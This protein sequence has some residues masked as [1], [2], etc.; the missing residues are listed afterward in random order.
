MIESGQHRFLS[1]FER[2]K[3]EFPNRE[4]PAVE[5]VKAKSENG[6]TFDCIEIIRPYV[7][8]K[9]PI[10]VKLSLYLEN[11]PKKYKLSP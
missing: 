4:Y 9:H 11:N 3:I 2:V 1:F 6:S 7:K 5:W 8:T 10:K